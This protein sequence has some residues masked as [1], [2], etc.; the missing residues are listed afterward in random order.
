MSSA[1][2]PVPNAGGVKF[3]D[4]EK[5]DRGKYLTTWDE[6]LRF[7]DDVSFTVYFSQDNGRQPLLTDLEGLHKLLYESGRQLKSVTVGKK[8]DQAWYDRTLAHSLRPETKLLRLDVIQTELLR[9]K[10]RVA[11]MITELQSMDSGT[12]PQR[13]RAY[14][15]TIVLPIDAAVDFIESSKDDA[16][17][18]SACTMRNKSTATECG[19]CS[20]PRAVGSG[21]G[22]GAG[23]GSSHG[24]K[25][26]KRSRSR[27][28]GRSR[29][30]KTRRSRK[31][32]KRR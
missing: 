20:T 17:T 10:S 18:C 30:R 29:G 19:V 24:G 26:R 5:F 23:A 13:L 3:L 16:W 25:R 7:G 28:R 12:T 22:G 9:I 6:V 4:T 2:F 32:L 11:G 27:N 21:G 8:R 1:K 14:L 31:S 15:E